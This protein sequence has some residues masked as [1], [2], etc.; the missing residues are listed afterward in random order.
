[1]NSAPAFLSTAGKLLFA[2]HEDNTDFRMLLLRHCK[3]G[4]LISGI[5][6]ILVV[7]FHSTVKVLFFD[8]PLAWSYQSPVEKTVVIWDKLLIIL[9]SLG[10]IILSRRKISLSFCRTLFIFLSLII[11]FFI[12][13]DDI[14]QHDVS[15]SSG[16]LTILLLVVISCIPFKPWQ[17]L[18]LCAGTTLILYPGLLIIPEYAGVQNL[19][20]PNNQIIYL[21][22]M[23]LILAGISTFL[24]HSRHVM[25]MA[26][27]KADEY[28][29]SFYEPDAAGGENQELDHD[30][31]L[32]EKDILTEERQ[33]VSEI[34]VDSVDK[35]FLD[36]VK[37]VIEEHIGDSNFGVEWLAHEVAISPRQLQRRLKS[38]IG[39]SAGNLIRVMR[40]QRSAQLIQQ[41]AGNISEVAYKIGFNDPNYFSKIFR[42]RYGMNPSAYS[43]MIKKKLD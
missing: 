41:N 40:L 37:K 14:L 23:S 28:V 1:M 34:S 10:V 8:Q 42:R 32:I 7:L 18:T 33:W 5:L 36:E 16:Y 39:L 25:Y 19:A 3:N 22:I 13:L 12:L 9:L 27:K 35:V 24:Y 21:I 6:G 4:M 17:A 38:A 26:R 20:M 29:D 43:K 31:E 30:R 15:F 11:A 2:P